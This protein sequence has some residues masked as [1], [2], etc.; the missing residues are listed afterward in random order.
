MLGRV[1]LF[2]SAPNGGAAVPT[3]VASSSATIT[4]AAVH[5]L[6]KLS[7]TRPHPIL[8]AVA[9]RKSFSTL[10]VVQ[11]NASTAPLLE[12]Y[13]INGSKLYSRYILGLLAL[14]LATEESIARLEARQRPVEWDRGVDILQE[15]E[16]QELATYKAGLGKTAVVRVFNAGKRCIQI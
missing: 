10:V 8:L 11:K 7:L 13:R 2:A 3:V 6:H 5:M 1:V 9:P 12:R 16:D 14:Q 4:N 15:L